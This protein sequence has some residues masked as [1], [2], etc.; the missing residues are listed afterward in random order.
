MVYSYSGIENL[1]YYASEENYV[2]FYISLSERM[3]IVNLQ[4]EAVLFLIINLFKCK[5]YEAKNFWNLH[6]GL[7]R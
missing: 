5:T 7:T 2:L 3:L 6:Y 4:K 1:R